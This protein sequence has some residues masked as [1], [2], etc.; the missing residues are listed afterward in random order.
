MEIVFT[1][2]EVISGDGGLT[3]WDAM[4]TITLFI[5]NTSEFTL[6]LIPVFSTKSPVL[7]PAR[8][9]FYPLIPR[10]GLCFFWLPPSKMLSFFF[11]SV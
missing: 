6:D 3:R 2:Y 4:E 9:L 10:Q 11:F 5:I 7:Q 8:A 1:G